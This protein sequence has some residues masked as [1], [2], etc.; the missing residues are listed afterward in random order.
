MGESEPV[1]I[2]PQCPNEGSG[3]AVYL[4]KSPILMLYGQ[5]MYIFRIRHVSLLFT[6][7]SREILA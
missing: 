4:K 2:D 7:V 3:K 1:G 5:H 6:S